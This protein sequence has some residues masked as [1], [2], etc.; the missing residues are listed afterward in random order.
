[1]V[2]T[3][4]EDFSLLQVN[5]TNNTTNGSSQSNLDF[6]GNAEV[7]GVS[8]ITGLLMLQELKSKVI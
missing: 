1:M 3:V 8:Q 7:G 6:E 2:V 4:I 5:V